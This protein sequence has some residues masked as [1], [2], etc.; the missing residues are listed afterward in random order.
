[1][2]NYTAVE[3]DAMAKGAISY[4]IETDIEED[5][6]T[7]YNTIKEDDGVYGFVP[8]FAKFLLLTLSK[9]G[10][11][12]LPAEMFIFNLEIGSPLTRISKYGTNQ[13]PW[14]DA[15][16]HNFTKVF[17]E[18]WTSKNLEGIRIEQMT[19]PVQ[20]RQ[21]NSLSLAQSVLPRFSKEPCG[22]CRKRIT[23]SPKLYPL[24]FQG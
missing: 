21:M 5:N 7:I 1:M 24:C 17:K 3:Y 14:F 6:A 9:D 10:L 23:K 22:F 11:D 16:L 8:W 15:L 20:S 13:F 19:K 4:L 18:V 2:K 12:I